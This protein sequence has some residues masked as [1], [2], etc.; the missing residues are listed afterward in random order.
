MEQLPSK[1]SQPSTSISRLRDFPENGEVSLYNGTLTT[2]VVVSCVAKIKACFPALQEGFYK[3]LTER[4]VD[5]EFCDERLKDAVNHV[6]DNCRYPQPSIADFIN[7]D[8]TIKF[9]TWYEMTRDGDWGT[10]YPVKFPDRPKTVWIHANDISQYK[11]EKYL[12]NESNP[13]L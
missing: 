6:I 3:T 10:Y 2:P 11:L 12:V 5:K 4:I 13:N 9:K 7:F 1:Y 8:K